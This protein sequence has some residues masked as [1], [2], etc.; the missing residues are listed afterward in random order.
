MERTK[1]EI[2]VGK[3]EAELNPVALA[4]QELVRRGYRL[5]SGEE[6]ITETY[7]TWQKG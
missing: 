5:Y 1:V 7:E 4:C 3:P 2:K 6:D